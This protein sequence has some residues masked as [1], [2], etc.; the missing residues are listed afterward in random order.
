MINSGSIGVA[1]VLR[2]YIR[3]KGL[4]QDD[5]LPRHEELSRRLGIGV[6]RLREGLSILEQQGLIQT[7]RRGGTRVRQPE[8]EE[9]HEPIG[10]HLD[11][12]GYT[13][14]DLVYARAAVESAIAAEAAKV[15]SRLD[16]LALG[17]ALERIETQPPETAEHDRADEDFHLIVLRATHNPVM[18]I[19]GQLIVGQFKRKAGE[20]LV[21]SPAMVRRS[22]QTHRAIFAAV[23][24][25]DPDGARKWMYRHIL[26]QLRETPNTELEKE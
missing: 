9:L 5:R 24:K 18:Q 21:P 10:W 12:M 1:E 23:E 20:N 19:F 25:K 11:W 3:D 7:R 16:L 13:F 8:V 22:I 15:R 26:D 17:E 4:R 2:Q 14:T 6:H